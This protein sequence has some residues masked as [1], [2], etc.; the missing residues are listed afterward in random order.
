MGLSA[1]CSCRFS[2]PSIQR[3]SALLATLPANTALPVNEVGH[4]VDT[5]GNAVDHIMAETYSKITGRTLGKD[6]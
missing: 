5:E 4:G 2:R 6:A 1:V 3:G